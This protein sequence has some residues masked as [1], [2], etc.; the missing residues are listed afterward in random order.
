MNALAQVVLESAKRYL[1]PAAS[2][3]LARELK[4]IG[5]NT[6]TVEPAH[7]KAL[8]DHVRT[9]ATEIMGPARAAELSAAIRACAPPQA[10]KRHASE[11]AL[12][13]DAAA[14]LLAQGKVEAAERAYREIAQRYADADAFQGLAKAALARGDRATALDAL[15]R[16]A[17]E[18]TKS[19]DRA[20][21]VELLLEA[22]RLAPIDL[23]T[24]RKLAAT[25]ANQGDVDGACEEYGRF[26]GAL[27]E[28][29]APEKAL[30][31]LTY[32]REMLGDVPQLLAIATRVMQRPVGE[33]P[34]P[35]APPAPRP[36]PTPEPLAQEPATSELEAPINLMERIGAR[37]RAAAARPS[38]ELEAQLAALVPAG[39]TAEA[40]ATADL[41][42]SVL[43]AARDPRAADAA[44]DAAR[45]HMALGKLPAASDVLLAC[46]GAG[47]GTFEVHR[48]LVDVQRALGRVDVAKQNCELLAKT[49]A[50]DGKPE[51][52]DEM[53]RL[54]QSLTVAAPHSIS[55]A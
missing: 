31:E 18:R 35:A 30:L 54:A 20:G 12:A 39:T 26:V 13:S 51:G 10:P 15:R 17:A 45:R 48:A 37:R 4:A 7:L 33:R 50:L 32:A 11:H 36:Q 34:R 40:A 2:T 46:L 55:A 44:L 9:A 38:L 14:H 24:H 5:T 23:A 49:C 53:A 6:N 52:A 27:L 21:A 22:A 3:F 25:L 42:A 28:H 47:L 43:I 1:G 16:A 41:R 8:S 19:G 29:G